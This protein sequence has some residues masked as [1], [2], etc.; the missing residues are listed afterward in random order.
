MFNT[1]KLQVNANYVGKY[2][3]VISNV[4]RSHRKLCDKM[5]NQFLLNTSK[6]FLWLNISFTILV[7][8]PIIVILSGNKDMMIIPIV[9]PFFEPNSIFGYYINL[10]NQLVFCFLGAFSTLGIE[11]T[12][13]MLK[14]YMETAA[15]V[16]Q[17][18]MEELSEHLQ[19]NSTFTKKRTIEFRDIIV[20]IQNF[21]KLCLVV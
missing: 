7:F 21:D 11:T 12:T 1:Q 6:T 18:E 20:K 5:A 14:S 19:Q 17:L 16:I 13:C 10:S 2:F 8:I 9:I 4:S 3:S 15:A